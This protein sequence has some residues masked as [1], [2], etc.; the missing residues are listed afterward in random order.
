M[1][2]TGV[3]WDESKSRSI[4]EAYESIGERKE[5][6]VFV[7]DEKMLLTD[8]N[9]RRMLFERCELKAKTVVN[10]I[11]DWGTRDIWEFI[12][13]EH[14][15]TNLLYQCGYDRVGCIGCPMAG[16]KRWKEFADFPRIKDAYIRTFDRMLEVRKTR[17][18]ETKWK[19]G[20]D[21]FLWWM[22]DDNIEGQIS[23]EDFL[24]VT[25]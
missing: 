19:S 11:I 2:A 3:R 16:K 4:R 24:E 17:K 1:I 14:V 5:N 18:K 10:P 22:E 15:C 13:Q 12:S 21:V 9:D 20:Y 23:I 6:A 7:S 25:P 8:N